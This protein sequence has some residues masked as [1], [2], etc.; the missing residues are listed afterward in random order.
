[1]MILDYNDELAARDKN[2]VDGCVGKCVG[3]SLLNANLFYDK[4][5]PVSTQRRGVN[6]LELERVAAG[7]RPA[8][9]T[10]CGSL[11]LNV[12][13]DSWEESVCT[14]GNDECAY[15]Q[16]VHGEVGVCERPQT[17]TEIAISLKKGGVELNPG[18]GRGRNRTVVVRKPKPQRRQ[19]DRSDPALRLVPLY[20]GM[21][22]VTH[23][24]A[25]QTV[26]LSTLVT[27]GTVAQ[28]I[29]L[30][31]AN[32][33]NFTTRF[34]G[35]DEFRIVKAEVIVRCASSTASGIANM[36]FVED[37]SSNPSNTSSLQAR[38]IRFN[39]S[40]VT[41]PHRITY[42]PHDPAQQTWTVVNGGNPTIGYF[43]IY[44]DNVNYGSPIVVT[45]VATVE[46][47]YTVQF[48][49]FV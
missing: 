36:W 39:W 46:V 25:A 38:A 33:T 43:K 13:P 41:K 28:N 4:M 35:Y 11:P 1:M 17:K 12:V 18:P 24:I 3:T 26:P 37:T 9:N 21:P 2:H 15:N 44:T 45:M 23:K 27:S 6:H 32:I 7:E 20:K 47:L 19:M 34:A 14:V 49:G 16:T 8:Q 40:D 31:S 22:T 29:T 30:S 5:G 42:K 48:R 10:G